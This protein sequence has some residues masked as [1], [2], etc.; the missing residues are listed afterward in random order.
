ML[1][2]CFFH[3]VVDKQKITHLLTVFVHFTSSVI[4]VTCPILILSVLSTCRRTRIPSHSTR[5]F[6]YCDYRYFIFNQ[7]GFPRRACRI[8]IRI[9]VAAAS[10]IAWAWVR[11]RVRDCQW[12]IRPLFNTRRLISYLMTF[13]SISKYY[14]SR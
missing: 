4:N 7:S 9:E 11:S 13:L 1:Y 6:R 8:T 14:L 2:S 10:G 3:V 5:S 12:R